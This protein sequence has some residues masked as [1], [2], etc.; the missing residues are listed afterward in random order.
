MADSNA[1]V[2]NTKQALDAADKVGQTVTGTSLDAARKLTSETGAAI[3]AADSADSGPIKPAVDAAAAAID[4]AT[5]NAAETFSIANA[6]A[7][8]LMDIY[9][10]AARRSADH[11]QALF[12]T[13]VTVSRG[14][15]DL[16][17]TW[18]ETM[19]HSIQS[20]GA[21]P[22]NI[23]QAQRDLYA[24]AIDTAFASTNRLL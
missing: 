19:T 16:H 8:P 17:V 15:R 10:D 23:W 14:M 22:L 12:G 24:S 13:W 20:S 9:R 3:H 2:Q 5:H 18:L 4:Q 11:M 7:A 21:A 6:S 1:P